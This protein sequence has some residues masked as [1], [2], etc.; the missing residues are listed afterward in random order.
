MEGC[1]LTPLGF[2]VVSEDGWR[3]VLLAP[4]AGVLRDAASAFLG[5]GAD[6]SDAEGDGG[7]C[8]SEALSAADKDLESS[9]VVTSGELA[10]D[11]GEPSTCLSKVGDSRTD[12]SVEMVDR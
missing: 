2:G 8:S 11:W 7:Y 1:G 4:T 3:I 9:G 5:S 12:K 10:V 6:T